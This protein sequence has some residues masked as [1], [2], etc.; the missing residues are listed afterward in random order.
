MEPRLRI[1]TAM[2]LGGPLLLGALSLLG[3]GTVDNQCQ[4]ASSLDT[5]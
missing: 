3:C 4:F 2:L 1:V 5:W